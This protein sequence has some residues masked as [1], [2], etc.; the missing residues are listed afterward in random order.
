MAEPDLQSTTSEPDLTSQGNNNEYIDV[1][2]PQQLHFMA[3]LE[4]LL[5]IK[6]GYEN[7][8]AKETWLET[9]VGRAIYSTLRECIEIGVGE[10]A[11]NILRQKQSRN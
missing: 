9:A 7:K 8:P 1:L 10:E 4:R 5:S 2:T 11:R 3:R 6:N